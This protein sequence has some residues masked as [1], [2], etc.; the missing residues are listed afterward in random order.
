MRSKGFTLIELLVVIGIITILVTVVLVAINPARQFAISRDT[1]RR[2]DLYQLLN[3]VHQYAVDQSG[4][5]PTQIQTDNWQD[6]GTS[7]LNLANDL[8]P[9]YIPTIPYD[10]QTGD[11]ATTNY[12]L[13]VESTGRLTASASD[14][15]IQIPLTLTR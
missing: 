10:P 11:A 2:N 14:A 1:A 6:I 15:E 3:A 9:T 7:G 5:F 8:A 4:L 12:V 13:A